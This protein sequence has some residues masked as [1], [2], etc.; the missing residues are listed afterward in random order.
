MRAATSSTIPRYAGV[1]RDLRTRLR[2]WMED[3]E[4]PLL[5]GPVPL[6]PRGRAN[7]PRALS[8][9]EPLTQLGSALQ[10]TAA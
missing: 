2:R 1:A 9:D 5:R 10:A 4:D 3:T 6:P 7:D 8:A